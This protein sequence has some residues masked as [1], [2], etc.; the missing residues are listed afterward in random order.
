MNVEDTLYVLQNKYKSKLVLS[1][2][3][4]GIIMGTA[5]LVAAVILGIIA[6]KDTDIMDSVPYCR[7]GMKH[8]HETSQCLQIKDLEDFNGTRKRSHNYCRNRRDGSSSHSPIEDSNYR[9]QMRP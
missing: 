5:G 2:S 8:N 9:Q 6:L 1:Y 4:A 3:S 7:F